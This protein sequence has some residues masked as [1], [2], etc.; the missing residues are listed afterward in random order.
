MISIPYNA[1]S[2]AVQAVAHHSLSAGATGALPVSRQGLFATCL[3]AHERL[4]VLLQLDKVEP[5]LNAEN[6][7]FLHRRMTLRTCTRHAGAAL[8]RAM[9]VHTCSLPGSM[10]SVVLLCTTAHKNGIVRH[11]SC[12]E[13]E[14]EIHQLKA[15]QL[16]KQ[17][18]KQ[19]STQCSPERACQG[20]IRSAGDNGKSGVIASRRDAFIQADIA[21]QTEVELCPYCSQ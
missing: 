5:K 11:G 15:D 17:M 6:V 8:Q 20:A 21:K 13:R 3:E 1:W 19:V 18:L 2:S 9:T 12:S 16:Q 4:C 10:P 7:H 14:Y